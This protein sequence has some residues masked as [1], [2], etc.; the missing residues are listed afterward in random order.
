MCIRDRSA[1]CSNQF[2]NTLANASPF[3]DG[4]E[5][6]SPPSAA[7]DDSSVPSR[8]NLSW[9]FRSPESGSIN[10]HL[11]D[12]LPQLMTRTRGF[13]IGWFH[14]ALLRVCFSDFPF[15]GLERVDNPTRDRATVH[16]SGYPLC[17]SRKGLAPMPVRRRFFPSHSCFGACPFS[18]RTNCFHVNFA[19]KWDRHRQD[20]SLLSSRN[21]MSEPVPFPARYL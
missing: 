16:P 10:A 3:V 1:C 7:N 17:G 21:N 13:V 8:W 9:A 5:V 12:V 2:G 11:M 20:N 14:R 15:A 19:W 6:D 4:H 18:R